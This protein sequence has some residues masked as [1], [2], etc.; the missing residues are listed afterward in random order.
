MNRPGDTIWGRDVHEAFDH[1]QH[2]VRTPAT[3]NSQA[4]TREIKQRLSTIEDVKTGQITTPK[5]VS[6]RL[7]RIVEILNLTGHRWL[8]PGRDPG[9]AGG[10][11][12]PLPF[13]AEDGSSDEDRGE[14][15][16]TP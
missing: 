13:V 12:F 9:A 4:M 2:T 11:T 1:V 16:K 7:D 6:K 10:E 8:D 15:G 3:S 14:D 5:N